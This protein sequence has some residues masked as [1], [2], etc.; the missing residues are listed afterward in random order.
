MEFEA[1]EEGFIPIR[2]RGKLASDIKL[3]NET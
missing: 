3:Y 2:A 1:D